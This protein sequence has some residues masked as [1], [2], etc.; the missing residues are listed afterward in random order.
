[1]DMTP[2]KRPWDDDLSPQPHITP[3]GYP[4]PVSDLSALFYSLHCRDKSIPWSHLQ[5]TPEMHPSPT[6]GAPHLLHNRARQ[7]GTPTVKNS[8]AMAGTRERLSHEYSDKKLRCVRVKLT[9]RFPET[10]DDEACMT[11]KEQFHTSPL[12]DSLTQGNEETAQ[13]D[14]ALLC[15]CRMRSKNYPELLQIPDSLAEYQLIGDFSKEHVLP[16]D[17]VD[18]DLPCISAN[19]VAAL[20]KGDFMSTVEDFV[21]ID[22]RYPYEY[23]GGHI[24]GAVNLHTEAQLQQAFLH[25]L[26]QPTSPSPGLQSQ[27][28]GTL[29]AHHP[30][31]SPQS[32]STH[33]C[34]SSDTPPP[35]APPP[36]PMSTWSPRKLVVFHCEMSTERGP[37]LCKHLRSLDR[38]LHSSLYPCLY[39]PE[40]Y[41]LHG[42]YKRFFS[43]FP[44][45]CEP[46]GYVPMHHLAFR[47]Q[48]KG[49][50]QRRRIAR[51]QRLLSLTHHHQRTCDS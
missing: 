50:R 21:I 51:R 43:C 39:H 30:R 5:Q 12:E 33:A 13:D 19:T 29:L 46:R 22:C 9:S 44:E 8:T 25:G 36:E 7:L 45:L 42:G 38:N 18:Q 1:M 23:S 15:L 35:P 49:F 28:S 3:T 48:L 41:L 26:T 11:A 40:V 16:I 37:R 24:E 32:G 2:H 14:K 27:P 20:L 4:S 31:S 34:R 10:G 47:E 6:A 17:R